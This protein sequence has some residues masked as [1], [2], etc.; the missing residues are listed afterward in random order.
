MYLSLVKLMLKKQS[1][2]KTFAFFYFLGKKFARPA[3]FSFFSFHCRIFLEK[4]GL[5]DRER[6][7]TKISEEEVMIP[8]KEALSQQI[9]CKEIHGADKSFDLVIPV[10]GKMQR[11]DL[12]SMNQLKISPKV[13]LK[14]AIEHMLQEKGVT[15]ND[16]LHQDLCRHWEKHDDLVFLP[17]NS[18]TLDEWK[19]FGV[20]LW[21]LVAETLGVQRLAKK[22]AISSDGF[23]TPNV[24]LLYG[25]NGWVTDVDNGIKY[26][27]DVTK[28]MFSAGNISEKIRI[29]D[30]D[31]K[32]QTVVD[33]YAGIGY[34]VLPYLIH[35][36]AAMVYACEW[37]DNAIDALRKNLKLNGVNDHCIIYEGDNK[38]VKR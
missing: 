20:E 35:A 34:F 30:F 3:K 6:K 11:I 18:F 15:F 32:G 23:R 13:R 21:K 37:N 27:F 19:E 1:K 12:Q 28:C 22:S 36:K 38:K 7:M 29:G 10:E 25:D 26:T 16:T 17:E 9:R 33:L 24:S 8:V 14:I 4:Q 2:E 31:C 5:Y